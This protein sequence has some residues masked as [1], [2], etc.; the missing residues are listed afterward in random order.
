[1]LK[2]LPP[3]NDKIKS[4]PDFYRLLFKVKTIKGMLINVTRIYVTEEN[5]KTLDA[6]IKKHERK[7]N[8]NMSDK[9]FAYS[10]G[11]TFLQCSPSYAKHPKVKNGYAWVDEDAVIKQKGVG[12]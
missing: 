12:K 5:G 11:M 6:H 2:K 4:Y 3:L 1:M 8:K 10:W 9:L 7:A